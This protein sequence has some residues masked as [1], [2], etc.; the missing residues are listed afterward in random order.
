V[1]HNA[2]GLR[3]ELIE[4]NR[5]RI[6]LMS[7]KVKPQNISSRILIEVL[8]KFMPEYKNVSEK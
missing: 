4:R 8:S 5:F 1:Q 6:D 2:T 7:S 3:H